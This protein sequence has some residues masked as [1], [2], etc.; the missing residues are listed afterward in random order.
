MIGGS[1]ATP[2]AGQPADKLKAT[3]Q[4]F[5]AVF[6]RQ[7]M[8]SMRS[9]SLGDD[10]FGSSAGDQFRD[11]ADAR[12]ADGMAAKGTFGIAELLMAQLGKTVPGG[13]TLPATG[14]ELPK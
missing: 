3:A 12:T 6:I 14:E 5:E 4:A 13:K 11:L 9:A 10:M 7:I 1:V 2:Q 8:A